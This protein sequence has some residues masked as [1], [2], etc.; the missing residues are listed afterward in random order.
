VTPSKRSE[1]L[2]LSDILDAIDKTLDYTRAGKEAFL[3]DSRTQDAVLRNI[4]IIGEA[5]RGI[6]DETRGLHPEI[7]WKEMAGMRDRIIHDYFRVDVEVVWDVVS[8]D[9]PPLREQIASLIA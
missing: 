7:P 1:R 5:V 9:L 2:Y 8:Q 6:T 3:V 4:E